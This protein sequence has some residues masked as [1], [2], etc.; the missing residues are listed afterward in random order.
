VKITTGKDKGQVGTIARVLRDQNRVVVEGYNLVRA[1]ARQHRRVWLST[2]DQVKK[3]IKRSKE[4][5]GG[6]VSIEAPLHVSNVQLV[7]PV[8]GCAASPTC[9]SHYHP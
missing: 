3:H 7:D 4:Q 8:T 2:A 5:E 6:I 9:S 1:G